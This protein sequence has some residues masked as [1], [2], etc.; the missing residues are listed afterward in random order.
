MDPL[1]EDPFAAVDAAL[2][3]LALLMDASTFDSTPILV[4][5]PPSRRAGRVATLKVMCT[6]LDSYQDKLD[7]IGRRHAELKTRLMRQR[8][9]CVSALAPISAMPPE[10]LQEVFTFVSAQKMYTR[11]PHYPHAGSRLAQVCS[12]WREVA[13]RQ[14]D[15][16]SSFDVSNTGA[17]TAIDTF[18][19]RSGSLPFRLRVNDSTQP[20]LSNADH[21]SKKLQ[22]RLTH[23]EWHTSR[24]FDQFQWSFQH[25]TNF[26][27]L[28][29]LVIF[30]GDECSTC[31]YANDYN[32]LMDGPELGRVLP[33][34]F[35]VL[36]TLH[37]DRVYYTIPPSLLQTLTHLE[38]VMC[39]MTHRICRDVFENAT[40]LE[41][42]EISNVSEIQSFMEDNFE[43]HVFQLPSLQRVVLHAVPTDVAMAVFNGCACPSLRSLS[44]THI[45]GHLVVL[46]GTDAPFIDAL[47]RFV[48]HYC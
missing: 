14:Q 38:I 44:I 46:N 40:V 4:T 41:S 16:W 18:L 20:S 35:P 21:Y 43:E 6:T 2:E 25:T 7:A 10:L 12:E 37:L 34:I 11:P 31:D 39:P 27:L 30:G 48:C 15:L 29:S 33:E 24:H 1:V 5:Q 28:Q 8:A 32:R 26:P 17:G 22:S 3:K 19:S 42:L 9:M 36:T 23:L 45:D 13:L 47:N